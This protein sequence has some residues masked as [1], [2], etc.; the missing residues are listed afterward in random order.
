VN[1]VLEDSGRYF[2]EGLTSLKDNKRQESGEKFDK[3]VEAFLISAIN[4]QRDE[5]LQRCYSQL[6]ETIYRLEYP[7]ESQAPRFSDLAATCGWNWTSSDFE[8]ANKVA[9]SLKQSD[10]AKN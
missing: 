2:R 8:L 4:V 3:S 1:R 9:A 10:K 5:R 7:M 6:I